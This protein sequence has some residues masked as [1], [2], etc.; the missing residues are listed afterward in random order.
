MIN[1]LMINTLYMRYALC[2]IKLTLLINSIQ[3]KTT[4]SLAAYELVEISTAPKT[5]DDPSSSGV[6]EATIFNLSINKVVRHCYILFG[7][8][9]V[10]ALAIM[11]Y[12]YAVLPN[13]RSE[14]NTM[15]EV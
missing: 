1:T 5:L 15:N 10:V 4:H 6:D 12:I 2:M 11:A 7:C 13:L 8:V 9:S 3:F 14:R